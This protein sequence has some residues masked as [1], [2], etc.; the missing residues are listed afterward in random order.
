M[1]YKLI[2]TQKWR[3]GSKTT[4]KL[5]V[6]VY[7]GSELFEKASKY[8][9]PSGYIFYQ[10]QTDGHQFSV[11]FGPR[12]GVIAKTS[13]ATSGNRKYIDFVFTLKANLKIPK[14]FEKATE[15]SEQSIAFDD[16]KFTFS[17]TDEKQRKHSLPKPVN[18]NGG[19]LTKGDLSK[20]LEKFSSVSQ[21]PAMNMDELSETLS[22]KMTDQ[23]QERL[24]KHLAG[25]IMNELTRSDD[26][27]NRIA[28]TVGFKLSSVLSTRLNRQDASL[29]SEFK[30]LS[31]DQ[32]KKITKNIFN[33]FKEAGWLK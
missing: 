17:I 7:Q 8:K 3:S 13:V 9:I 10:S 11:D 20:M 2:T 26:F 25:E 28:E 24:A 30:E 29:K 4:K 19:V 1:Q 32:E 22:N 21:G 16:D 27:M 12:S 14:N 5:P 15:I 31:R 18:K 6:R 33:M 23:I